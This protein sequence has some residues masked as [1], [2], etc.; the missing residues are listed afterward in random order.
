MSRTF[1][2]QICFQNPYSI[3]ILIV[4]F[5]KKILL[6]QKY[7]KSCKYQCLY[8]IMLFYNTDVTECWM[9]VNINCIAIINISKIHR[10]SQMRIH[11]C[12]KSNHIMSLNHLL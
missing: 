2:E 4:T 11:G 12:N 3:T 5:E 9:L 10:N 6:V 7:L 1:H 8:V